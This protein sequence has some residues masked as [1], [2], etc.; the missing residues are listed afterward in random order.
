[1]R[2]RLPV[3]RSGVDY[4]TMKLALV[5]ALALAQAARMDSVEARLEE[6]SRLFEDL[7]L[8][9]AL[10][11]VERALQDERATPEQRLVAFTLQAKVLAVLGDQIGSERAFRMVLRGQP[12][13][14]IG[15]DTSPK[16]VAIF[17]KVQAEEA[18]IVAETRARERQKLVDSIEIRGELPVSATGGYDIPVELTVVDPRAAV[19]GAL[20]FYKQQGEPQYSSVPLALNEL[21]RWRGS[22]PGSRTEN[23]NGSRLLYYVETRDGAGEALGRRHSPTEP[24]ALV[25][26]AGTVA[27]AV[28]AYRQPWFW[29]LAGGI[30]AA[31]GGIGYLI[32]D[33]RTSLPDTDINEPFPIGD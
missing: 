29:M 15:T 31:A 21:G 27:S 23:R 16:I 10:A 24:A 9:G 5:C 32:Y 1:M 18:A 7:E 25:L 19:A 20:V 12:D 33:Q 13:Y 3:A 6:A 2:K 4:E 17:R 22:I 11:A 26:D 28:P 8:D 14:E 30:A